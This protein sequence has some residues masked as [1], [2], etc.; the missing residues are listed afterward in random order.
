MVN[1]L[2]G[3]FP[4]AIVAASGCGIVRVNSIKAADII[5]C[6][7]IIHHLLVFN[8]SINGLHIGFIIQGR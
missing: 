8:M 1:M 3:V 2:I 7:D 5:I 4:D 6:M